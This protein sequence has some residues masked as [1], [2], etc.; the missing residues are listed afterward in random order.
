M[1]ALPATRQQLGETV[2]ELRLFFFAALLTL[3]MTLIL[4]FNVT[5]SSQVNVVVGEPAP[6]DVFA[7]RSHTYTSNILTEKAREQA[8]NAISD[9]YT[10]LDARI[11]REQ[12]SQANA[13]FSFIENVYYL[14]HAHDAHY[15]VWAVRGFGTAIMHGGATALFA[16][17][18]EVLTERHRKMNWLYYVPGLIV[19]FL[20]HSIFNHFPIS[21]LLS[22]T[23]T[24]L[25]LPTIL[26]VLFERN[27]SSIHNFLEMDF[28]SHR[29]LLQQIQHGEF[30]GCAAGR[31]LQDMQCKLAAPVAQEM[32][33]YF[34]LHTE[35]VLNAE[36][37]LLAR[38]KGIDVRVGE[39]IT[40][41]LSR[42]HALEKHIGR[43][44]MRTLRPHLQ[45]TAKDMWEIHLLEDEIAEPH[46]LP[47]N[48]FNRQ[49]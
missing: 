42:M 48:P 29:A 9:S 45:F 26:F 22:T 17:T 10:A 23:V 33:D 44:G 36:S 40:E 3:G 1:E 4:S 12:L 43:A 46:H 34:V 39:E 41:K 18:S 37:I 24:L 6:A 49:S 7:P 30:T 25:I 21:P 20:L 38:E 32:I 35:L 11:G 8:R 5:W 2:R 27:E 47:G 19:A 28:A 16:I 31:F 14:S 13:T 15:G